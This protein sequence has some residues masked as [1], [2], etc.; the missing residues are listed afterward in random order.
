METT[1]LQTRVMKGIIVLNNEIYASVL[2]KEL[3]RQ[4]MGMLSI[5]IYSDPCSLVGMDLHDCDLMIIDSHYPSFDG[6][7]L[8]SLL[9]AKNPH[10]T[11]VVSSS[12]PDPLVEFEASQAGAD[13]FLAQELGE[14]TARLTAQA[15]VQQ[16][17][18]ALV[19]TAQYE[20]FL[21][22]SKKKREYPIPTQTQ[23]GY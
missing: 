15:I 12:A 3:N 8:I 14:D 1:K 20:K 16:M 9:K 6:I 21:I 17:T 19:D 13:L 5:S 22:E 2:E 11:L 4:L 18:H 10:G 7:Q 23:P